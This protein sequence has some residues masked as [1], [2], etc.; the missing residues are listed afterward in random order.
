MN[1]AL[2]GDSKRLVWP[3][4]PVFFFVMFFSSILK[5]G[6]LLFSSIDNALDCHPRKKNLQKKQNKRH[7]CYHTSYIAHMI[8]LR[9]SEIDK[10]LIGTMTTDGSGKSCFRTKCILICFFFFA[11]FFDGW[12][13]CHFKSSEVKLI[14]PTTLFSRSGNNILAKMHLLKWLGCSLGR[15]LGRRL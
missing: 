4:S 13:R 9:F 12:K 11:K 3:F 10:L 7:F 8:V 5:G 1:I 6:V 15:R 14:R 2:Y